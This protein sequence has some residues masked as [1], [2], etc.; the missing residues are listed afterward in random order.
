MES[1]TVR[2]SSRLQRAASRPRSEQEPPAPALPAE[3]KN[4]RADAGVPRGPQLLAR[5]C[6]TR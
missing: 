4:Q 6:L 1:K 5:A 2:A 3:P